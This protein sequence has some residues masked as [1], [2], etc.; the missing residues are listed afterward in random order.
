[1]ARINESAHDAEFL[2]SEANG[3]RS[4]EAIVLTKGT[5]AV[6]SGALL[7]KITAT[8][9]YVP[10]NA[11]ATDGSEDVAGVLFLEAKGTEAGDVDAVAIVR[12]AEIRGAAYAASTAA[13]E[14]LGIIVRK[15][16]A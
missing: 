7:G 8:G 5:S 3:Y 4:R 16:I 11:E 12:D 9:K 6:A 14:A 2:I 15:T 1:M 13:L 10:V